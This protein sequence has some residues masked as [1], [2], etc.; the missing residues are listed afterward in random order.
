M[1]TTA[2]KIV[3][4]LG[5]FVNGDI[6]G[7][8]HAHAFRQST[9]RLALEQVFKGNY[10]PM[11][12][13]MTLATGK[14][15][16]ARAYAAGF[17]TLGVV[18]QDTVKVNYVGALN[19][20][21]N[22]AARD[23]IAQK[24]EAAFLAFFGAFDAVMAEKAEKKE[25]APKAT[26]APVQ[27]AEP[28]TTGESEGAALHDAAAAQDSAVRALIAMLNAGQLTGEQLDELGSA[29]RTAET[30]DL[31]AALAVPEPTKTKRSKVADATV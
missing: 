6:K 14:A 16:K 12:E 24:T 25:S 17:A 2:T 20:A 22:K 13:A 28:V 30:R 8:A 11:T 18:G 15:K 31:L 4:S 21:D 5:L 23:E 29:V 1:T 19:S 7:G 3:S 27:A 10:S 9:I 26:D